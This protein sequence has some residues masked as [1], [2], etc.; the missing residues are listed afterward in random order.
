MDFSVVRCDRRKEETDAVHISVNI[1]TSRHCRLVSSELR[2]V[3]EQAGV[4]KE[5]GIKK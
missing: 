4:P 5:Q 3:V 1:R 2:V